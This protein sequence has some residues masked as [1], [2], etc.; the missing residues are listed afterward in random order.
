MMIATGIGCSNILM[1]WGA[2]GLVIAFLWD[3]N[4]K[5]RIRD[6][7]KDKRLVA[8]TCLYLIFVVSLIHTT[9]FSYALKDLKVKLP[10]FIIPFFLGSFSPISKKEFKIIFHTLYLG[11]IITMV[12]GSLMYLNVIHLKMVDM[13]SY[14]P[15]IS[16]IRVG[17]L[18]VFLIFMSIYFYSNK[19]YRITIGLFYLVFPI[20]A[21]LFLLLLQSLTGFVALIGTMIILPVH[22]LLKKKTRRPSVI[23]ILM[24]GVI[25]FVAYYLINNE[26][27]RVHTIEQVNFSDLPKS[28]IRGNVY[29]HDT[30]NK[31]TVNGHYIYINIAPWELQQ[32]WDKRSDMEYH[33]LTKKGWPL[34]YTLIK[35]LASKGEKKN[36]E[37]VST[38]TDKEV[39]AI[40]NG[41]DNYLNVNV[42]DIRYRFNQLWVELDKYQKTGDPNQQSFSTRLETWKVARYTIS[43]SPLIGF[44]TGD[45]RDQMEVSYNETGSKLLP[46]FRLNPHQQY[47]STAIAAGMVGLII[48]VCIIFFPILK[49]RDLHPLFVVC[50]SIIAIGMLDEDILDT[51]AGNTQFIFMY[52][53]TYLLHKTEKN[54]HL[55]ELSS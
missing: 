10:L 44:G 54:K 5:T 29:K 49:F 4:Y 21:V 55:N 34:R 2:I 17:T 27:K 30:L 37:S 50:L 16:H 6:F 8:L 22:G 25:A 53:L 20:A 39:K 32:A 48:F 43:K 7:F 19:E 35:Y 31:E 26:Y 28:T 41:I 15:F 13:R 9:N 33:G 11:V 12:T 47:L 23:F 52:V 36:S 51:Q 38:L 45:V 1:S 18:L 40:E 46:K 42:L 24:F 3:G 14:S